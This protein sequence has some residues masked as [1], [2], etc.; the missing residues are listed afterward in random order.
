MKRIK[1]I[2][3]LLLALIILVVGGLFIFINSLKPSYNGKKQLQNLSDE[4]EVYFDTYGIPHIYASTEVDAFKALGYVHA[5]DRLWQMELLR[6]VGSG[7]LSE[8]FGADLVQTDQFLLTLGIDD[9]SQKAVA[10]LDPSSPT[11]I[12]AE[13]YL[14]G[15]NEFIA[16]GPTPIE[17]YLTGLK[18]KPF[19]LTDIYNAV[20][21]MAFSFAMAHKTDPLLTSIKDILGP[22]YLKDL[23]V[24][25]DPNT[26]YIQSFDKQNDSL[27]NTAI[28]K[29]I[30]EVLAPLPVPLL[31]GS[32]G[33][34]IGPEKTKNGKVIFANDPHIGFAQ[35]SVWY[36]AHLSTPTYEKYGYHLAGIPFPLLAHDRKLAYGLT[37]FENDDVDF[38]YETI[39]PKDS[40]QYATPNG[41]ASF[42]VISKTIKVKDAA[43]VVFTFKKTERGAV[44]NGIANQIEGER[45]ITMSWMY[46]KLDN[47]VMEAMY[48]M[49]HANTLHEFQNAMPQIHAPGLNIMYGDAEGNVAWY[50]AAQLYRMPD[51][52]H[53]KFILDGSSGTQEALE[54]L[55][56]SY[57]PKAV[58]PPWHYVYSANN[59]P[60][61]IAG[62]LYP[63]YYLPE[64]RAKRTVELIESNC[65]W[66]MEASRI[67][68]T[69][70]VSTVDPMVVD[71]LARSIDVKRLS[72]MQIEELDKLNQW[73]GEY[74]LE[75]S[76]ATIYNRWIYFYLKYTF[77][78]ELGEDRFQQ[79]LNTHFLKRLIAPMADKEYSIW[80]DDVTTENVIETKKDIVNRSFGEAIAS[81]EKDFGGQMSNWNWGKVHTLEHAHPIGQIDALRSFF[82]VGPFPINGAREVINN[83]GFPYDATGR[84][85]VNSGPSTRRIVDFSDIENS[86]SILPTGQSGN[87]FSPHYKDQAT[88]YI[89]GEFRKMML[90]KEEI[91]RT[92][93]NLL[94]F[95]S[96]K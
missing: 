47:K 18:K 46:T 3:W 62:R 84:Y 39:N 6:R 85:R 70:V 8:V 23:E 75:S 41:W 19:V 55:D 50:A 1:K 4:V 63:G 20:G 65:S 59:Q 36:E 51:S 89:N 60:D 52:V 24:D 42:E 17:F 71:D 28:E 25:S 79:M 29:L 58:N 15:V 56:F 35:P 53:T 57:N 32:N 81:L 26:T 82:N 74:N 64:N 90:N 5:Q 14:S 13:S 48:G 49:S 88:M 31:E 7:G 21:Y 73:G 9:A 87:P 27:S 22:D 96:K 68:I 44:L 80:W 86:I 69:D 77:E 34:V 83:L 2:G 76:E 61:T 30:T 91:K 43:D 72:P 37:M 93:P 94:R 45:P 10:A 92:S 54:F 40:T 12:M 67:M 38:Y 16:T 11:A 33:W 78:D 66:D 95:Q